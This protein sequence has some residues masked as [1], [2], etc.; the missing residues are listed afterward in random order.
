MLISSVIQPSKNSLVTLAIL[1]VC[2][3]NIESNPNILKILQALAL[4]KTHCMT[5]LNGTF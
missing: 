2:T 1:F 3:D 4:L 5:F